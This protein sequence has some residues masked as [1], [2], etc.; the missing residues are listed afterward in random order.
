MKWPTY[1]ICCVADQTQHLSPVRWQELGPQLTPQQR[2]RVAEICQARRDLGQVVEN[3]LLYRVRSMAWR[4][5]ALELRA[6]TMT[7]EEYLGLS[8]MGE[9][10]G[11]SLVVSAATRLR[12]GWVLEQR[13]G[14]VA[15][16]AGLLHVKPSGH[17]HPPEEPWQGVL[18]EAHEELALRPEEVQK[19]R[20]LGV[21]RSRVAQCLSMVYMLSSSLS[22]DEIRQRPR[23]DAWESDELSG[24][25]LSPEEESEWLLR[26]RHTITGI[27]HGTLLL[28]MAACH[29]Q[30]WLLEM[31]RQLELSE[32]DQGLPCGDR[33]F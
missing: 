9:C 1:E 23:D 6:E 22:V 21:I 28:A 10:Q 11:L 33:R 32:F 14:R 4:E 15:E 2:R 27:G 13:S 16:G 24:L 8:G 26:E 25:R 30:S 29:G 12:D 3:H 17:V 31:A 5:R 18:R 19:G 7:Y 20:W